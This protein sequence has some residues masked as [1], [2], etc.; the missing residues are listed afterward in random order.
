MR[1]ASSWTEWPTGPIRIG[2]VLL[3][4][5]ATAS[6]VVGYSRLLRELGD[7]ASRNSALSYM[8]REIAGGNALVADQAAVYAARGLIP[9][10]ATYH[11]AVAPDYK[12]ESELTQGHVASYYRYFLI[13]RRPVEGGAPWVICYG[14][15]LT[16]YGPDAEVV[17]RGTGEDVSIV[18]VHS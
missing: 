5:T 11:V 18:R 17:W 1:R 12:G 3:V 8:D 15:D 7:D 10:D 4:A 16:A 14:C 2:V 13:P 9:S 6:V